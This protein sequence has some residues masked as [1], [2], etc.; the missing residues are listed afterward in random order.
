M[1]TEGET[2]QEKKGKTKEEGVTRRVLVG[3]MRRGKGSEGFGMRKGGKNKSSF[4]KGKGKTTEG[5]SA[6]KLV[7]CS[8]CGRM[9]P[10]PRARQAQDQGLHFQQGGAR[11]S[12][13]AGEN[14]KNKT[15]RGK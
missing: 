4:T 15:G 12:K 3:R 14:G 8:E 11:G 10:F 5:E 1:F 2:R 7:L 13:V 9:P 6:I